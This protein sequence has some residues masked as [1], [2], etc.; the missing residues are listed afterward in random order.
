MLEMILKDPVFILYLL[1]AEGIL[2]CFLQLRTNALLRKTAKMRAQKKEAVRQLREEVKNGESKIPV[3][4]F[5]K[6]KNRPES[7]RKPE[8]KKEMDTNEMAVLQ[9]MMTEF[10]G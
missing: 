4:K 1:A 10:F 9:E 3:V 6:P 5:E 7:V 2:I 8:P